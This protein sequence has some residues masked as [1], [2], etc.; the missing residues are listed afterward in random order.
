M[1]ET[2]D[3]IV[4]K[5]PFE[6][7]ELFRDLIVKSIHVSTD[8]NKSTYAVDE[9]VIFKMGVFFAGFS[10]FNNELG[11]GNIY[12]AGVAALM[13]IFEELLVPVDKEECFILFHIRNLGKFR[14]READLLKE[15][16]EVWPKYKEFEIEGQD[17]SRALKNLMRLN[18]IE[19]RKG[20]LHFKPAVVVRYRAGR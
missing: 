15:L 8:S 3:N 6:R 16:K 2:Y 1:Q 17:F 19:Y 13:V 20:N 11:R 18:L 10:H 12:R 9:N 7:K 5:I 14:M 4:E